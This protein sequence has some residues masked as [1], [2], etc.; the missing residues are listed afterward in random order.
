MRI[1]P[2]AATAVLLFSLVNAGCRKEEPFDI[3]GKWS[4]RSGSTEIDIFTFNGPLEKGI[5]IYPDSQTAGKGNYS[6][7]GNTIVFDFIS[8]LAGGANYFFNGTSISENLLAG[9]LDVDVPYP[10]WY[11]TLDVEGQRI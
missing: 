10:P 7:S 8:D 6:V 1:K 11:W 4:F 2:I 5:V 9:T 3:R